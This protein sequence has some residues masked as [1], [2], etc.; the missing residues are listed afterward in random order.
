MEKKLKQKTGSIIDFKWF[1]VFLSVISLILLIVVFAL[2][3]T[4]LAIGNST[5]W[6]WVNND[7]EYVLTNNSKD[8]ID[9]NIFTILNIFDVYIQPSNDVSSSINPNS[10]AIQIFLSI[11]F[12]SVVNIIIGVIQF[13]FIYIYKI[14]LKQ[15]FLFVIIIL[16]S[17]FIL[18]IYVPF[19]IHWVNLS[20]VDLTN[21]DEINE[22]PDDWSFF[23]GD[24]NIVAIK[25]HDR[26]TF[27]PTTGTSNGLV[28][29]I[30]PYSKAGHSILTNTILSIAQLIPAI[31]ILVNI[32]YIK[33]VTKKIKL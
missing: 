7:G 13:T 9:N 21:W 3:A 33:G 32:K 20:S 19:I 4:T 16:I 23:I 28:Y 11:I 5:S 18:V 24:N 30:S 6:I 8:M 10:Q 17:I 22:H 29:A 26:L 2:T 25:V 1:Y 14:Y 27:L 15:L 12:I 31:I